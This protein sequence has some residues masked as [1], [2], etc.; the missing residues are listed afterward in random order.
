MKI[1]YVLL[2][3]IL[4]NLTGTIFANDTYK[5]LVFIV[6]TYLRSNAYE[7]AIATLNSYKSNYPNDCR[8]YSL[9][10]KIYEYINTP[11]K[12]VKMYEKNLI[13]ATNCYDF[14]Y[15]KLG[16]LLYS[17]RE[18]KKCT[19]VYEKFLNSNQQLIKEK[20][21]DVFLILGKSFAMLN[22][23]QKSITYLLKYKNF[24][25]Y[26]KDVYFYLA[27]DYKQIN[28]KD[29]YNAY[30]QIY[31]LLLENKKKE[32]FYNYCAVIFFK[33]N[34]YKEAKNNFLKIY[35]D[36][37]KDY[38]LN[39]NLGLTFLF[40]KDYTH[41]LIFIKK[42]IFYYEKK[43]SLL[44]TFKKLL[45]IEP[46]GAQY[47]LTLSLIYALGGDNLRAKD[48]LNKVKDYDISLYKRY[49]DDI[50]LKTESKFYKKLKNSIEF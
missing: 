16:K 19:K 20:Y 29:Y 3:L 42:A 35:E 17:L 44:K 5:N 10:E 34:K 37:D 32:K 28:E 2:F 43:F 47:Y 4:F 39:Y 14:I 30:T 33:N 11:Y 31:Y 41:S 21:N 1:K 46:K 38:K 40:L 15:Y 8:V 27:K 45:K 26:N 13:E 36:N 25:P 6:N 12:A 48:S 49:K 24:H 22:K 7:D 50:F 23:P 9:Y 18:Y